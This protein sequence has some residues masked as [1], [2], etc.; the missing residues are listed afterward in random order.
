MNKQIKINLTFPF[1]K[2]STIIIPLKGDPDEFSVKL[3]T[4]KNQDSK[5]EPC[6]TCDSFFCTYCDSC[7]CWRCHNCD[8]YCNKCKICN[9]SYNCD[10]SCNC[11]GDDK[12]KSDNDGYDKC[13]VCGCDDCIGICKICHCCNCSRCNNKCSYK[14]TNPKYLL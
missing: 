7:G 6:N 3:E 5:S 2:P 9:Y 8:N 14:C 10:T 1:Y 11:S 12:E 4:N 13:T